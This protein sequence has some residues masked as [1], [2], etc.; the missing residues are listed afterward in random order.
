MHA[1][2][3]SIPSPS[4]GE[5]SLGPITI[6]AYGLTLLLAIAAA[7]WLTGVRWTRRGGDWDLVFRVAV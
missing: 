5:I 3:A 1:L 4:S 2:L 6:H 7:V